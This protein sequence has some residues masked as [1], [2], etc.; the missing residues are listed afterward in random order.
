MKRRCHDAPES[1]L[2]SKRA[3]VD[4]SASDEAD[5]MSEEKKKAGDNSGDCVSQQVEV[6]SRPPT[7]LQKKQVSRL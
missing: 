6:C 7:S 2:E 4:N 3:K 5:A 1:K